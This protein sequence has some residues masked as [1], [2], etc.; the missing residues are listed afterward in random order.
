MGGLVN[1]A[2]DLVGA[3][4][5]SDLLDANKKSA[6]AA[7]AGASQAR[8]ALTDAYTAQKNYLNPYAQMGNA[9]LARQS[10]LLGLSGN[11]GAAGYGTYGPGS[12]FGMTELAQDPGYQFRLQQGQ[13]GL[14]NSV[15]ARGMNLSGAAL[16]G[17]TA[18][19][20][21]MASQEYGNAYQRYMDKY[22]TLEGATSTG[23]NTNN[24]LAQYAGNYG[25]NMANAYTGAA[26][27]QANAAHAA[28]QINSDITG[29]WG[30]ALDQGANM[31]G[32]YKWFQG[33]W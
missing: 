29:G 15:A 16:K 27:D 8:G 18:Y 26:A 6:R 5:G 3:G 28:G 25:S 30:K 20:S 10:D 14:D 21:G 19:N 11:T 12:S 31:L 9:A 7:A 32:N 17:A 33:G 13:R 24:Q 4:P 1:S 23:A 22:K 2:L